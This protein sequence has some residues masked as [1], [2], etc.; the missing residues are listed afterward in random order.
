MEE[1]CPLQLEDL[2]KQA[3]VSLGYPN[4]EEEQKKVVKSF[5]V[6]KTFLQCYPQGMERLYVLL[7]CPL[8][9]TSCFQRITPWLLL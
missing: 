6:G 9:L 4:L 1:L 7:V 2:C 8:S 3:A 5:V